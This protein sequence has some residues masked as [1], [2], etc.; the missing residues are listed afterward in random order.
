[1]YILQDFEPSD[2]RKKATDTSSD[3]LSKEVLLLK[4]PVVVYLRKINKTV[5]KNEIK[6]TL[7]NL[8]GEARFC[9]PVKEMKVNFREFFSFSVSF[10]KK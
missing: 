10:K 3:E 4:S 8:E 5:R 2:V 1:M 9:L 6:P 7:M